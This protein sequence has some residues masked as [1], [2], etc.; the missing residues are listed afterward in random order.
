MLSIQPVNLTSQYSFKGTNRVNEEDYAYS[1]LDYENDK[2]D[3]EEQLR[4]LNEVIENTTVPKPIRVIGKIASIGIGAGL[5]FVSMKFGAQ[6]VT[7]LAKKGIAYSKELLNKPFAKKVIE[8]STEIANNIGTFVK[9]KFDKLSNAIADNAKFKA[10]TEKLTGASEK[11]KSSKV[12]EKINNFANKVAESKTAQ[13]AREVV[14]K[15]TTKI[16][17]ITSENVENAVVNLFAVSGGVTGGI[18]ALQDS[19]RKGA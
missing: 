4:D 1:R 10:V 2:S 17:G 18:T 9:G 12:G 8:K 3:L 7:K 14:D 19:V 11:I 5:G 6:G 16:K 15:A 13:K